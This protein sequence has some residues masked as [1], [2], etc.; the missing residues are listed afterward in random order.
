LN[1]KGSLTKVGIDVNPGELGVTTPRFWAGG[2]WTG[3]GKLLQPILH[4]KY[5]G[6]WFV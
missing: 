6:K 4:K 1:T 3:L 2:S 5:V